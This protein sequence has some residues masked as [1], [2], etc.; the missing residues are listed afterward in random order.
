MKVLERRLTGAPDEAE[1]EYERKHRALAREAAAQGMVLLRN[2]G[3]IL[4]LAEGRS[5]AL[6]GAGAVRTVKGGTGSGDVNSRPT[7]SIR[8]GLRAA[9]FVLTT[10]NWLDAYEQEYEEAREQWRE[11]IWSRIDALEDKD[12]APVCY[13][14]TPFA[15]PSGD[16]PDQD[17]D[18]AG[19]TDT[20]VYV[21]ARNAGE[22][23][24]RFDRPGDYE[25]DET[26]A[27]SIACLCGRYRHVIL[28]LN[29][30]GLVDLGFTDAHDNID[31]ILYVHQPGMEA[32]NAVAD[33]IS[34]RTFPSGKLTDSWAMRYGDYPNAASFSHNNGNVEREEYTEGLYVGYR[35]FDTF[36]VPVRYGFGYG[37]GYTV[38]SMQ[39]GGMT[40]YD[41]GT[42]DPS[43]GV[44]VRVANTGSA[45]GRE[46]AQLYVSCPQGERDGALTDGVR[47]RELRRLAGFAKTRVLAPRESEE[48][49]IRVPLRVLAGYDESMPGWVLESGDYVVMLGN[50]LEDART[51]GVIHVLDRLVFER[52]EHICVPQE[53]IHELC[54]AGEALE[55]LRSRREQFVQE[56]AAS[57]MAEFSLHAGDVREREIVYGPAYDSVPEEDRRF[58]EGLTTEQ[59]ILLTTGD[60]SRAQGAS[61]LGDAGNVVPGSAAQTSACAA[62]QGLADI[63]L[64]D[65]P[66]GL[67]LSRFYQV[68]DG[69]PVNMPIMMSLEDGYL[70]RETEEEKERRLRGTDEIRYQYTTA[71]PVGTQLAQSWD[72]ALVRQI[73]AAAGEELLE[74]GVTLWLAP[75]MNIHRNPLCGRNFEYYSEDPLISGLMAA[76]MTDGVQSVRGV[77]TTIKHFACNNQ[78]DN[79]KGSNSVLTERTLREIYLRGFEIA[80]KSSQPM[81]MMTSYNCVN[82]IHAANSYDLCTKAARNEW[83]F[84]GVIMT[85]WTTTHDGPDCTASGCM[86]AGNDLVMPGCAGDHEN[87]RAELEAGTLPAEDLARSVARLVHTVRQSAFSEE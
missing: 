9:G 44:R 22:G 26:E 32:G 14:E 43:F 54:P 84:A 28:I 59:R 23:A 31:A 67:R 81:S 45:S 60:V 4:P 25:L 35:Y 42:E 52:T 16:L 30:G 58:V 57:G 1:R 12:M 61:N 48:L 71:F 2:R 19:E 56:A 50:S 62:E 36:G 82:G 76:A 39:A 75:G 86:R 64:A 83:G 80:V 27:A 51:I 34:G 3:G 47:A 66:A 18:G 37:L 33:V 72:T 77:G 38:F 29:T 87:M 5:I 53:K 7:V 15:M 70:F 13:F 17:R 69:R 21:L 79:R 63:V 11:L 40:H 85:D 55:Q 46:V 24:D 49:D 20:A 6:Y 68:R 10:E 78:E 65:G 41:L 73:G 74:F 8:D